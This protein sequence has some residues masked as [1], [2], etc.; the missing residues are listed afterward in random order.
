VD[1]GSGPWVRVALGV[2]A[3]CDP[4]VVVVGASGNAVRALLPEHVH[5]VD[6]PD[7]LQGMG[8]SLRVGLQSMLDLTVAGR[9]VA[10][11]ADFRRDTGPATDAA[12]GEG[13]RIDAVLVMLV[14]L[15]GVGR[16]VIRRVARAAAA[17]RAAPEVLARAAFHGVP[18]HPVLIGRDHWAGVI[19]AAGGDVGARDYLAGHPPLLIECGDIGTGRDVD[20]PEQLSD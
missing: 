19:A 4:C 12:G 16:E 10:S 8:S 5:A 6:N 13:R 18:G 1:T 20:T 15:P 11:S 14:D 3:D 7:H 17:A 9:A 2:L